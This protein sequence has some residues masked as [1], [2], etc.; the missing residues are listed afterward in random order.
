VA[1]AI[2]GIE[3]YAYTR[4]P[5]SSNF[6]VTDANNVNILGTRFLTPINWMLIEDCKFSFFALNIIIQ[7]PSFVPSSNVVLRRNVVVDAYSTNSHS[8]GLYASTIANLTLEQNLF[9]H[10]GFNTTV[11]GAGANIFNHNIYLQGI[12]TPGD[13]TTRSG[14]A[15]VLSNIFAND[16]SG[17]QFRAGG[18][19]TDRR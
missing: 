18:T 7:E 2:D 19:I 5:S 1:I 17:P 6:S 4:D 15:T 11:A 16:P 8:Q 9:D 14:P 13:L 12:G 3:F 10:N